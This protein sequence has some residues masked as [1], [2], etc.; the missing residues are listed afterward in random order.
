LPEAGK[1]LAGSF[2]YTFR[3]I[4]VSKVGGKAAAELSSLIKGRFIVK[5]ISN[6]TFSEDLPEKKGFGG[7]D[8]I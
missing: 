7:F 5:V 4:P 8:K 6:L 2:S 1:G 3:K